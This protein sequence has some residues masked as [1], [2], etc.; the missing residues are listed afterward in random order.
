MTSEKFESEVKTLK[1]FFEKYCKDKHKSQDITSINLRYKNKEISVKL[2][3]CKTCHESISYSFKRL[4][5]CPHDV[6]PRCRT[7]PSKC[8]AK[9]EW[10]NTARIMKYSAIKLGLSK[11]KKRL[12]NI[13]K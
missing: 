7:C 2:H 11:I 1:E 9:K 12:L 5:K 13:F 6:K 10:G 4:L 3:L 8:Y